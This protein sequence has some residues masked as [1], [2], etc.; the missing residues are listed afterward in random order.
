VLTRQDD[1]VDF[2]WGT[3]AP[4]DGV[5][6]N[7]FS[8]RWTRPIVATQ[9]SSYTFTVTTDDGARLF[10]DGVKVLDKW[11]PQGGAVTNTVTRHLAPGTHEVVLEYLELTGGAV[12]RFSYEASAEPPP[13]APPPFAAEYFDNT[14]LTGTPVL[15]RVDSDL[16][17]DWGSGSPDPAVPAN[18]FSARWTRTQSY[19]EGTYRLTVTGDDGIRVLVDGVVV[20]DG[21]FYQGPTTYSADVPLTAGLHTVVVEYFEFAGG[22]VA[23]FSE[24]KVADG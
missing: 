13:D 3:G 4:G 5:P 6:A 9:D 22:A 24:S 7:N 15:A 10:V 20:V 11:F 12:A 1:A 19:T 14:E 2:N 21:W 16:D 23:A 17:F 8:A 18:F